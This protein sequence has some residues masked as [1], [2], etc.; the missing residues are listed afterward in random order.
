VTAQ[1]LTFTGNSTKA[2]GFT[3]G[4]RIPNDVVFSFDVQFVISATGGNLTH[5]A[6]SSGDGLGIQGGGNNNQLN[7]SEIVN[8][9]L[10]TISNATINA[11]PNNY[12]LNNSV[13]VDNP[14]WRVVRSADFAHLTE[15]ARASSDAA[16][17]TDV[18]NFGVAGGVDID[19]DFSTALYGPLSSVYFTTTVGNWGL[20]GIGYRFDVTVNAVPEPVGIAAVAIA[21]AVAASRRCNRRD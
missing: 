10:I 19:N 12:L 14:L 9:S 8:F 16:A 2:S 3:D 4:N 17:T 15:G 11:D 21:M 13:M 18:T 6:I 1:G 7:V 20:K 5:A